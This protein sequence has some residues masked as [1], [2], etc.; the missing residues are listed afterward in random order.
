M[1]RHPAAS[2]LLACALMAGLGVPLAAQPAPGWGGGWGAGPDLHRMAGRHASAEARIDRVEVSRFRADDAGAELGHGVVEVVAAPSS[3]DSFVPDERRLKTYEAAVVDQLAKA[4]YDVATSDPAG[5]QVVELRFST[6]EVQPA[7]PPHKPVSGE[8][9]M[10]VSNH[11]SMMGMAVLVDLTKPDKALISTRLEA[12]VR[13]R[14]SGKVLWEGRAQIVTRD[15]D[16][17]WGDQQ[18]A[19]RLAQAL[20]DGFPGRTG[21]ESQRR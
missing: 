6:D 18:V 14:A 8:M 7:E 17:R 5:G 3:T 13:D 20:F 15:G 21:E 12:R 11:G 4:G 16:E 9:T 1:P 10:G 2:H 19:A